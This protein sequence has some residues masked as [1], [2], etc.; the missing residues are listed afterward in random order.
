ML[1]ETKKMKE[2]RLKWPKPEVFLSD[3]HKEP[4]RYFWVAPYKYGCKEKDTTFF[5]HWKNPVKDKQGNMQKDLQE[6]KWLNSM[7]E[8]LDF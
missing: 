1:L 8:L 4:P 5:D 7:I 6:N 3:D 2:I